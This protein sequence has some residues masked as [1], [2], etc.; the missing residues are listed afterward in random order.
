[1]F[2]LGI[3]SSCDET[4]AAV[5]QDGHWVLSNIIASQ[6]EIHQKFGGV[7]PELASR[8]HIVNMPVVIKEA[9]QTAQKRNSRFKGLS[10]VDGIAV[11]SGP[12]L[13][14]ALMIGLQTA[15]AICFARGLPLVGVNHLDAH[16]EAV[17]AVLVEKKG[18]V[19]FEPPEVTHPHVA[20]LVSGGHTAL[21]HVTKRGELHLMGGTRDDA[22]GEAFDKVAKMLGLGYPGGVVIEKLAQMGN[23]D[24]HR[25]PRALWGGGNL[26]FSFSGLKTAVRNHIKAHGQPDSQQLSDLCAS[27]QC[28]IVDV[29]VKKAVLACRQK[30][31]NCL[32]VAGGVAAN[33][34]LRGTIVSK[35]QEDD[36]HVVFP[37]K[38]L[39]TDNAAM[40]AVAGH[41]LLRQGQIADLDLDARARWVHRH[42]WSQQK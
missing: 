5:L 11:T 14:G 37:D 21:F 41:R 20:L 6:V 12:G 38:R 19:D 1:L 27:V 28:A 3:E 7:V 29:L 39:C 32:V 10:S 31:S 24:A 34:Y 2:V 13:V 33:G 9:M 42:K 16:L 35:A 25:F 18:D 4:A 30:S 23:S 22:A 36:I 40:V 17:H 8:H 15:K 26:D